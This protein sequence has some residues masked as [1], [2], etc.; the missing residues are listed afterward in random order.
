MKQPHGGASGSIRAAL[1]RDALVLA[2]APLAGDVQSLCAAAC[3]A[4][5]WRDAAAEPRL[6]TRI[7]CRGRKL[8]GEHL[9]WLVARAQG[10]LERLELGRTSDISDLDLYTALQQPHA[11]THFTLR[12]CS[13]FGPTGQGVVGA[14][15]SRRGQLRFLQLCDVL[16]VLEKGCSDAEAED[17]EA[18]LSRAALSCCGT[19]SRWR[20]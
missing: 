3:V 6:W 20:A 5:A 4:R 14:L 2:F 8:K 1:P 19:P 10:G 7:V 15:A 11:L 18:V 16:C 9:A 17:P 13:P 12:K